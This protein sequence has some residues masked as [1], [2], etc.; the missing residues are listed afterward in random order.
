MGVGRGWGGTTVN[1][2]IDE[3]P[4]WSEKHLTKGK[5]R[6]EPLLSRETPDHRDGQG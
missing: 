2:L 6:V 3:F 4:P 1:K 5:L